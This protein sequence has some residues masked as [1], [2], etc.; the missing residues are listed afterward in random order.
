MYLEYQ[1]NDKLLGKKLSS[2]AKIYNEVAQKQ[3]GSRKHHQ[4]DLRVLDDLFQLTLWAGCN[5][6][7]DTKGCF[8]RI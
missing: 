4:A 3:Q 1:I 8:D 7:N 6:M 2:S 5:G